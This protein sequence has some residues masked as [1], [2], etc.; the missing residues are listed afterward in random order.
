LKLVPGFSGV[1]LTEN[2]LSQIQTSILFNDQ[3]FEINRNEQLVK[4]KDAPEQISSVKKQ[5]CNA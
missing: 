5:F 2:I 1:K 4:L 3:H